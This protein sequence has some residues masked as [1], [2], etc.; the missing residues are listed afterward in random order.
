M[1]YEETLLEF[2]QKAKAKK[3]DW[4]EQQQQFKEESELQRA[5]AAPTLDKLQGAPK[6]MYEGWLR[7]YIKEGGQ[8]THYY[9]YPFS[10]ADFKVTHHDLEIFPLFGADHL[11]IIMLPGKKLTVHDLGHNNVFYWDEDG[12]PQVLGGW[13][14]VYADMIPEEQT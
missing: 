1:E 12:V 8:P 10:R 5:Q 11:S 6:S 7:N 14:P 9:D 4:R 2:H 13:I 3:A